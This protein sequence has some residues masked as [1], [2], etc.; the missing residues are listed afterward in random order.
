MGRI[1]TSAEFE[2]NLHD[3]TREKIEEKLDAGW[4]F[5]AAEWAK[6]DD[7][8]TAV[9]ATE[10]AAPPPEEPAAEAAAPPPEEPAAEETAPVEPAAAAE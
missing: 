4:K 1:P 8:G 5:D 2:A 6:E 7:G 3:K 10:A 9:P